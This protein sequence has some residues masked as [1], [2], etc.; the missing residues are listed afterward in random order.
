MKID[1]RVAEICGI[2]LGDGHM[3]TT[4]NRVTITG[5]LEDMHYY[6]NY[7]I[8]L[9]ISSFR[10][11]PSFKFIKN[12]NSC[13]MYI[14]NKEMFKFLTDKLNMHRGNKINAHIPK[15]ILNNTKL[16]PHFLRGIFDTDG[17]L[18]FSKQAK[19]INYYPR[20][21]L[22]CQES[23]LSKEISI[24]L[25]KLNF[26]FSE[27]KNFNKFTGF[28]N[29]KGMPILANRH[30]VCYEISGKNNIIKWTKLIDS[31]NPVHLTKFLIWRKMGL[32]F[33]NSSLYDRLNILNLGVDDL[34][35]K[36]FK[37]L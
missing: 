37:H 27:S 30:V 15:L 34:C 9:F 19:N 23:Y 21:R 22:C 16:I 12:K 28:K 11:N 26:N 6:K 31:S 14:N 10:V 13:H 3:H 29:S 18:K 7:V 35:R 5:S 20:I 17:S 1:W 36:P 2:I 25:N 4:E 32:G 33:P 8:P 24:L